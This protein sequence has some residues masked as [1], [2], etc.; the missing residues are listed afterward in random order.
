MISGFGETRKQ[1][2][3]LGYTDSIGLNRSDSEDGNGMMNHEASTSDDPQP[4]TSSA[5]SRIEST[6]AEYSYPSA[7]GIVF[8]D[9]PNVSMKWENVCS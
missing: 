1:R 4:S 8:C 7:D 2:S 6:K 5:S 3:I 9:F